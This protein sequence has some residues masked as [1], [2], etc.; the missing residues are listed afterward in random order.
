VS[1]DALLDALQTYAATD[2]EIDQAI[3]A[4]TSSKVTKLLHSQIDYLGTGLANF[5]NIFN[6][7]VVVLAGFLTSLFKFDQERLV[8]R[9]QA[10]SL[11]ASKERVVIRAGELGSNLLMVGAA[12][13]PLSN[14]IG[15][16]NS[17]L[18]F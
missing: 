15:H 17:L 10:G 12:E 9:M 1:R 4:G 18:V 14:V 3:S 2:E 11:D 6:P 8:A 13:R 5:V 16:P 7:E